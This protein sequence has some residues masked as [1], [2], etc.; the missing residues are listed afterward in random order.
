MG[1]S[2]KSKSNKDEQPQEDKMMESKPDEDI[3]V[4]EDMLVK[5]NYCDC[6]AL[7]DSAD[8]ECW[9]CGKKLP[10]KD[11]KPSDS[12]S[13]LNISSSGDQKGKVEV[14]PVKEP[15]KKSIKQE[16]PPKKE[17]EAAEPSAHYARFINCTKCGCLNEIYGDETICWSCNNIMDTSA[18]Y[19]ELTK[20]LGDAEQESQKK[21]DGPASKSQKTGQKSMKALEPAKKKAL[22]KYVI[23]CTK[24]N[25][26]FVTNEYSASMQ[27]TS[28]GKK[29]V[30]YVSYTCENCKKFFD[31]NQNKKNEKCPYCK[32]VLILTNETALY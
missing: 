14:P 23:H 3:Q 13:S 9:S 27:C 7:L 6:G 1:I 22:T 26:W 31:L 21:T 4:P 20:S 28:C 10:K 15:E 32:K 11:Q 5:F 8:T 19:K 18:T 24:C 25:S 2:D 16:V 12:S 29:N 30:L 17:E